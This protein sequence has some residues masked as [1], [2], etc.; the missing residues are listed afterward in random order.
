[1]SR[2]HAGRE[3]KVCVLATHSLAFHFLVSLLRADGRARVMKL[4]QRKSCNL[5][6]G[7][8]IYVIDCAGLPV[9]LC[10]C[11][12]R[13]R[14]FDR[15][16]R[17]LL[18]DE[19]PMEVTTIIQ[20][21]VHGFLT[22]KE[23]PADLLAALYAVAEGKTWFNQ[24]LLKD[25]VHKALLAQKGECNG[26]S[27]LTLREAEIMELLEKRYSNH[28]IASL[29][30][31]RNSTVKFHVSNLFSKLQVSN[32][33]SLLKKYDAVDRWKRLL[34]YTSIARP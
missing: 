27:R 2:V 11:L 30:G 20:L 26:N 21:G 15:D 12:P 5:D 7:E 32:R 3:I 23:V 10:G 13:L 8:W 4:E 18:L 1:M 6:S 9:P 19:A 33:H 16:A 22:Y 29:L 24:N 14:V 25:Y 34:L 28:E 31:I 17:F